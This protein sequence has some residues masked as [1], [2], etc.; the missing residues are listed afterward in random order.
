[1]QFQEA[2]QKTDPTLK[3]SFTNILTRGIAAFL[4]HGEPGDNS[5]FSPSLLGVT[6]NFPVEKCSYQALLLV[7]GQEMSA[8]LSE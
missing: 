2:F 8:L 1:M 6:G 3:L 7:T 5:C 4:L